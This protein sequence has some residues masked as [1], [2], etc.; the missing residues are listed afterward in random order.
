MLAGLQAQSGLAPRSHRSRQTNGAL[1]LAAA[2]RV[3]VRVHDDAAD[4]RTHAHMTDAASLA[5]AD[6]LMV[7]V[8]VGVLF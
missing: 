4:G 7:G 6:D 2:M 1:A 3:I 8:V 5:Q